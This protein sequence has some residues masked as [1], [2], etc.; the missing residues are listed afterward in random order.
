MKVKKYSRQREAILSKIRSTTSH[1]TADWVFQ[2]LREEWP[3]LSLG[4]VYRNLML[5]RDEGSIVSVA[6]VDGKERYD[7]NVS[8]HG[9]FVCE[10]CM[11]VLD[12]DVMGNQSKLAINPE[13]IHGCQVERICITAYGICYSCLEKNKTTR[14]R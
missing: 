10:E 13:N 2:E 8:P 7:G 1:P 14:G 6:T 12:I 3:N 11:A 9:H 4:T 5:F